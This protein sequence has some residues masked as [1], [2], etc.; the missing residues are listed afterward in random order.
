M[1]LVWQ[2]HKRRREM[3]L[4]PIYTKFERNTRE[5]KGNGFVWQN[6]VYEVVYRGRLG[7]YKEPKRKKEGKLG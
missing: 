2:L 6:L 5:T 1:F 4:K 3:R 7:R